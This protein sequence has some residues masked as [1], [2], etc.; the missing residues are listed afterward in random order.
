MLPSYQIR[1]KIVPS[2]RG[3]IILIQILVKDIKINLGAIMD[4]ITIMDFLKMISQK[5]MIVDQS[6]FEKGRYEQQ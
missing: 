6:R 1:A 3:I 5:L 2:R 4:E